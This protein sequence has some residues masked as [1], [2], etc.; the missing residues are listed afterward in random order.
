MGQGY[1]IFRNS[2]IISGIRKYIPNWL[3][4]RSL[5][6][7][8]AVVANLIYGFPGRKIKVIGITGTKGKTSTAHLLYHILKE[9]DLRVLLISTIGVKFQDK[10]LDSGLHVTSPDPFMLQKALKTALDD[11]YQYA[12]I[13][14]TSHGLAQYRSWGISFELGVFTHIKTDHLSYHGSLEAYRKTKSKLIH[15]SKKILLNKDDPSFKYLLSEV[16]GCNLPFVEYQGEKNDFH[17]QNES[18]ALKAAQELGIQ[19]QKASLALKTFPGV[20]GRMEFIQ[21]EPFTVVIDFA[22]TPDSFKKALKQLRKRVRNN[23]RL[24]AVFGCAGERDL[25]RRKMG[26]VAARY[27]DLFI[28]TAEDPRTESIEKINREISKYAIREGAGQIFNK[29]YNNLDKSRKKNK[30]YFWIIKDRQQAIDTAIKLAKPGDVV[31]LFGKGH[32]KS[33]CF[34][35]TEH[36]WSEHDAVKKALGKKTIK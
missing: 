12:V 30:A 25:G 26:A 14:V 27:S 29:Q 4:N 13:E 11:N 8:K 7:T 28:I 2:R 5:H 6:L 15:Q 17:S 10:E 35:K 23:G 34:G 16:K 32:E 24:I 22:H 1:Q 18:A 33:L 31:G 36:P 19:K 21:E 3:I 20:S 9:N